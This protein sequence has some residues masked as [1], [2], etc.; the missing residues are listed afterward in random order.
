MIVVSLCAVVAIAMVIAIVEFTVTATAVV[1]VSDA[2][3]V[4]WCVCPMCVVVY[5]PW[6]DVV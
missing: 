4:L 6:R 3:T 5:V 1:T 2:A